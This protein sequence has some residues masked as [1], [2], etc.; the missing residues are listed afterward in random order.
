MRQ[1]VVWGRRR[2]RQV[3][4]RGVPQRGVEALQDEVHLGACLGRAEAMGR[5]PS[6]E[7][8]GALGRK[9]LVV[10]KKTNHQVCSAT[11]T[12]THG[13]APLLRLSAPGCARPPPGPPRR[14]PRGAHPR[15]AAAAVGAKHD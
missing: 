15:G 13:A 2:L 14:A 6:D 7:A 12:N 4:L 9:H 8:A 11:Q 1:L 10:C 3:V 5:G